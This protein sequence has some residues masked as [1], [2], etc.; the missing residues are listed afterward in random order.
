MNV[1][2]SF[3]DPHIIALVLPESWKLTLWPTLEEARF[4]SHRFHVKHGSQVTENY[5]DYQ[6]DYL[7]CCR[8]EGVVES[9]LS[10]GSLF[11]T[12]NHRIPAIKNFKIKFW[13]ILHHGKCINRFPSTN[14][15]LL[16]VN[17]KFKR[18]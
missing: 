16:T 11:L 9:H 5:R 8:L 6:G 18:S 10:L 15:T 1:L 12:L 14:K 4:N 2:F 3:P 7:D 17:I 13:S